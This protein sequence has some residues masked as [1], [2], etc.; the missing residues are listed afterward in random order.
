MIF[1]WRTVCIAVV[2]LTSGCFQQ[3]GESLQPVSSTIIPAT[4]S[5]DNTEP[6][7]NNSDPTSSVPASA[8]FPPIT[9][10]SP[11]ETETAPDIASPTPLVP[12][13][14]TPSNEIPI[15]RQ[16]I[17]PISPLMSNVEAES[18]GEPGALTMPTNVTGETTDEAPI[19][20]NTVITSSGDACTYTVQP[21]D[22]LYRI[23]IV[24]GFTLDEMRAANPD[25]VGE[26]P[27]LQVGQILNLP[28]CGD[29]V[30]MPDPTTAAP[31]IVSTTTTNETPVGGQTYVVQPGDTLLAIANRLGTTMRALID[32][33][34]LTNPDRLSVGQVLII[35]ASDG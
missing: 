15:T 8:T 9:V 27:I 25:L 14:A 2:L 3:A 23:A 24:E 29:T 11:R 6:T 33:N 32:A 13:T 22:N 31:S 21:G 34:N 20:N 30:N 17:T 10:I 16:V 18:T 12:E 1:R 4:S 5:N 7:D 35:P 28:S 19:T 26:A